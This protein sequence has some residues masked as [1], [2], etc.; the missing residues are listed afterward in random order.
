MSTG[1]RRFTEPEP[2]PPRAAREC[3]ELCS[4]PIGAEHGHVVNLGTRALMCA[5]RSCHLL[6]TVEGAAMGRFVAVPDRYLYAPSFVL[7]TA[8]W[9]ELQ[10]PVR[11]A[12]FF[13]NSDLGR[14]VA[15]YPS[16]GGATE[17]ELPLETW[18]RVMAANPAL[19]DVLP[20]VEA[21]LV[22]RGDDGFVCHLVPIDSCYELVGLVR[23]RWKGFGGGREVWEAI[24]GFFGDLRGR[25]RVVGGDTGAEDTAGGTGPGA[26]GTTRHGARDGA[27]G[28]AGG[29]AGGTGGGH[30]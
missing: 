24:D 10:I 13:R 25:S 22:D 7:P 26:G 11:M 30:D 28:G 27:R 9:E 18:D 5:C 2:P 1:L 3:C 15:F 12:F 8:D 29:G 14:T 21:L 16:P 19:A 17:S 20:D 4:E 23:T 6:F